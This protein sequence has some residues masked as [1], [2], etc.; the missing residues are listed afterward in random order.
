MIDDAFMLARAGLINY[1]V[2]LDLSM[3]IVN[4]EDY[5]PWQ[6]LLA[7]L[8]YLKSRIEDK[9]VYPNFKTYMTKLMKNLVCTVNS[10]A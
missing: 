1:D 7:N 9:P 8:K 5:I 3:Y 6:T 10:L 2:A 4:E